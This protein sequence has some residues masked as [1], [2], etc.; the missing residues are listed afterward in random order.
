MQA[1]QVCVRAMELL[2]YIPRDSKNGIVS[3]LSCG[4]ITGL[5]FKYDIPQQSVNMLKARKKTTSTTQIFDAKVLSLGLDFD[6]ARPIMTLLDG[7]F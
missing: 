7:V 5:I 1:Q 2:N 4:L 3:E 6:K